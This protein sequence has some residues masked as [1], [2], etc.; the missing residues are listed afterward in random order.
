[1]IH[2]VK[3]VAVE[4]SHM[5]LRATGNEGMDHTVENVVGLGT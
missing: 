1:M 2:E 3:R 4:E 5:A